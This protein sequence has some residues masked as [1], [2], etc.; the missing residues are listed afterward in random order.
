MIVADHLNMKTH[1]LRIII[2]V[3]AGLTPYEAIEAGTRNAAAVME[4]LDEFALS[5]LASAPI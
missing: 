3:D 4:K 2:L 1:L 5:R